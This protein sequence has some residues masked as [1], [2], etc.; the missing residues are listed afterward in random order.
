MWPYILLF[1]IAKGILFLTLEFK[2]IKNGDGVTISFSSNTPTIDLEYYLR[3]ATD[4]LIGIKTAVETLAHLDFKRW[5]SGYF[6]PGPIYPLML[7]I[8]DYGITNP[9]SMKIFTQF[10]SFG[11]ILLWIS[12]YKKYYRNCYAV[13]SIVLILYPMHH[14]YSVM[15][16]IDIVY[17][18]LL[19]FFVYTIRVLDLS[20]RL[21]ALLSV[22]L[23]I[24]GTL[25]KPNFLPM[26]SVIFGYLYIKRRDFDSR[27]EY[28][29]YLF[30]LVG[31]TSLMLYYYLPYYLYYV[32]SSA[33]LIT[34]FGHTTEELMGAVTGVQL[35]WFDSIL[36]TILLGISKMLYLFGIRPSYTALDNWLLVLRCL[37]GVPLF[38]GAIIMFKRLELFETSVVLLIILPVLTGAT[39]ERY[40]LPI[41]PLLLANFI[42]RF[43]KKNDL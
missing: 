18:F 6:F 23:Y 39:Q 29:S 12:Y 11:F 34:Y 2:F 19:S 30:M 5:M 25:T 22:L 17:A 16:G 33:K 35:G 38:I 41:L 4:P 20:V 40:L 13:A 27:I 24:A 32:D 7:K 36:S 31:I 9:L 14:F 8:T 43:F 1:L 10:C 3:F 21:T 28:A 37:T 42:L 26:V 15:V